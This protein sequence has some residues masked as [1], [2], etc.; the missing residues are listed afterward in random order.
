MLPDPLQR[1]VSELTA[2]GCSCVVCRPDGECHSFHRRGVADLYDMVTSR[3]DFLSESY[4]AD[5]VVGKGA[6]ALMCL[7]G[8]KGV[9]SAVMSRGAID[10]F[11]RC[12]IPAMCVNA[13]DHIINRAGTEICPVER[14]CAGA[15][16]PGECLP[17][18]GN[19]LESVKPKQD[20]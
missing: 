20:K 2:T 3:P 4:V 5:K 10:M 8:V 17:L 1:A 9:W 19:F 15:D 11:A 16:T 7:G 13:V 6:A 18:I 14:L 12:G